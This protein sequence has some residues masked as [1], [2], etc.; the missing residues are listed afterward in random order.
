MQLWKEVLSRLWC[1]FVAHCS[2]F[3]NIERRACPFGIWLHQF[4]VWKHQ[5]VFQT[6]HWSPGR[7]TIHQ[8]LSHIWWHQNNFAARLSTHISHSCRLRKLMGQEAQINFA[9]CHNIS[10]SYQ[11]ADAIVCNFCDCKSLNGLD[12]LWHVKNPSTSDVITQIVKFIGVKA[13]FTWEL[14][15]S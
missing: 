9:T 3:V 5:Y 14:F 7:P 1:N 12:F 13:W 4:V 2:S 10:W 15:Q 6:E 8:V 11:W